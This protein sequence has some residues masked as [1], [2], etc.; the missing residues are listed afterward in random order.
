[1]LCS[2]YA[3][4]DLQKKRRT[5]DGHGRTDGHHFLEVSHTKALGAKTQLFAIM[6]WDIL[7]RHT[8]VDKNYVFQL[9]VT[10]SLNLEN[11]R[12]PL[13]VYI[14]TLGVQKI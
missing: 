12:V 14:K 13:P 4:D 6:V 7:E 8:Y 1:M 5:T 11:F 9:M 2:L 3:S 10:W